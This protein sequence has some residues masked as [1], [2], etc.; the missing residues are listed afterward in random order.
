M[1]ENQED[2]ERRLAELAKRMLTTPPKR[3]DDLKVGKLK[4]ESETKAN[5]A[6]KQKR[7][8]VPNS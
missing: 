5:P 7:T 3:R 8:G 6:K 2:E 1:T 4:T